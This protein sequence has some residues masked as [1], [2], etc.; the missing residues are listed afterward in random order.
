MP[1]L[2]TAFIAFL[3]AAAALPT[4]VAIGQP[5][6]MRIAT[7]GPTVDSDFALPR[8]L[9][10][11]GLA[12]SVSG[13]VLGLIFAIVGIRQLSEDS[14]RALTALVTAL[15]TAGIPTVLLFSYGPPTFISLFAIMG[16]CGLAV[17]F[18]IWALVEI[19]PDRS[20]PYP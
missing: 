8:L 12:V 1:K 13:Y 9:M 15:L 11:I 16:A 18:L 3:I 20:Q 17:P 6:M 14:Q 10:N 7:S 5:M 2:L 19:W 4:M